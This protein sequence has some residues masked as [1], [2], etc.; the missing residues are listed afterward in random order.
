MNANWLGVI[1]FFSIGLRAEEVRIT[2][3]PRGQVQTIEEAIVKSR[4]QRK[5]GDSALIL[6]SG[7]QYLAKPLI[8]GDT[9]SRTTFLGTGKG[10]VL[11]G[12]QVLKGWRKGLGNLWQTE[13]PEVKQGSLY[14]REL[15]VNG[16]RAQ[17]AR[18]PNTGFLQFAGDDK[19]INAVE[20]KYKQ[21][22]IKKAW[23][24]QGDVELIALQSWY[25]CR[26]FIRKVDLAR[27]IVTLSS[28]GGKSKVQ[29]N[30]RY[31]IEN[32]ADALDKPGEWFLDRKTGVLSY[33]PRPGE[34]MLK[35]SVIAPITTHLVTVTGNPGTKKAAEGINFRGINF[36]HCDYTLGPEGYV[37]S[38]AAVAIRGN[39]L[40]E[41]ATDC[42]IENCRFS[43]LGGY[44]IEIG[45]GSKRV[46]IRNCEIV[47]IGAG[48]AR[49]GETAAY[50]TPFEQNNSN[51]ITDCYIHKLGRV[52][53]P[54]VGVLIL[55]SATNLV[56][57]NEI[58]DLYYTA[59]SVGWNW[60]YMETLVRGNV[61][62]F[63]HLHDIGQGVLGDMGAV[64]TL[65]VQPGTVV[66][67]NLI[68]D[69]NCFGYGGWGLYTDE[70]SS[71]IVLQSN[72]VY[73]CSSSGFH[74]HYGRN[75]VIR[76]NVF[77]FGKEAQMMRT[78]E[79]QH[80]SFTFEN[81]I[82]YFDSGDLL[83]SNW[84]NDK[85]TIDRN[86]YFAARPG[87]K[88]DFKGATL[89]Q[90]RARGHDKNSILADP[91]FV[92]PKSFDFRLRTNS[93]ALKIGF[94]P[95]DLSTVGPRPKK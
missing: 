35:A 30:A 95:I 81:N 50:D 67:N 65:G 80:N 43:H 91:L 90:W 42:I 54:G 57:H 17:R 39:V 49:I 59:I 72:V 94:K 75:N 32:A 4:L 24:D 26:L 16:V 92:N 15:F 56:S 2:V 62:E 8:L 68:H 84:S 76:N 22:E 73:R 85:F 78:R 64:Y 47:D 25:D 46:K 52:F 74:Q 18:T 55:Q 33:W 40:F 27:Q 48:G 31:Y 3:G 66:Q 79:E 28:E 70:G 45:R 38:Q 88:L 93:P 69:V 34:N 20:L 19:Q 1:L 71:D 86:T 44:A 60:N 36:A 83:G 51:E 9:D 63:N 6:L 37:D 5:P 10:A 89:E 77:A 53:A 87:A 21:G 61:I 11:S 7:T 23:A 14:F 58:N 82:V 41:F 12:G 13:I 29:G